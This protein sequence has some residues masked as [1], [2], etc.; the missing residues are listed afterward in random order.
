[1]DPATFLGREHATN[2]ATL[3]VRFWNL[4]GQ[5]EDFYRINWIESSRNLMVGFHR[6]DDHPELG[7]CHL[8]LDHGDRTIDR[9]EATHLDAHP[10]EVLDSRLQQ[11]PDVLA[12]IEW[13]DGTPRLS[14]GER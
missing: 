3:E 13:R 10:L 6:D 14:N 11:L 4:G 1:M 12:R 9:W 7:A 5:D 2:E 8:Q